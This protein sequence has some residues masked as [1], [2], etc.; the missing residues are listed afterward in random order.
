MSLPSVYLINI[1]RRNKPWQA[2]LR[3]LL[4]LELE[5]FATFPW[6]TFFNLKLNQRPRLPN[7]TKLYY[8]I[9]EFLGKGKGLLLSLAPA[10][11][12]R[13]LQI[14]CSM[15]KNKSAIV[16]WTSTVHSMT[17]GPCLQEFYNYPELSFSHHETEPQ[18]SIFLPRKDNGIEVLPPTF[19]PGQMDPAQPLRNYGILANRLA[20]LR[21]L[22]LTYLKDGVIDTFL[23]GLL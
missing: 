16:Y 15:R 2:L 10:S 23:L 17:L 11:I 3:K 18:E 9:A 19:S 14:S 5:E 4:R 13:L 20:L 7:V 8:P 21:L 6:A 1:C 12:E 22:T